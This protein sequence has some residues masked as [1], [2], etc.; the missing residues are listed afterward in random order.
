M[1]HL[2]EWTDKELR[3]EI[4]KL[5]E[6]DSQPEEKIKALQDERERRFM[7]QKNKK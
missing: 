6:K 5:S 7:K 2:S 1:K 4:M 3:E